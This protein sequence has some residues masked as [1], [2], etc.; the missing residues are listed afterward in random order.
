MPSPGADV[1]LSYSREDRLV[2]EV[3]ASQL[4][5]FGYDVWWDRDLI[6][7]SDYEQVI[8]R[9]LASARAV[10]VLWSHTSVN[11]GWVRDEAA[12]AVERRVLVPAML[13]RNDG[14]MPTVPLGFRSL[15]TIP[16]NL[17]DPRELVKA[18]TRL[19]GATNPLPAP[20]IPR[21]ASPLGVFDA[22]LAAAFAIALGLLVWRLIY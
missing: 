3:V 13:A 18:V 16:L 17:D 20:A 5:L 1:F 11:S 10:V 21:P 2:A 9:Q 19:A 7:G 14:A 8:Q 12:T 4:G 15:H 6:S 22:I